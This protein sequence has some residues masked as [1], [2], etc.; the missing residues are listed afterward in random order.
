MPDPRSAASPDPAPTGG[1]AAAAIVLRP[2]R[3]GDLG[4]VVSRHGA[5]YAAEYGWDARFEG[6]VAG[7]VAHFVERFEPGLECGVIAE[8][9]G[10][11]VGSVF[12]V[13]ESG[14]VAKLRLL[15]VEPSARGIGLGRRLVREAM[16][17]AR[18]AGY[19]EM[20]LWTNEV[21][22][23]ARGIYVAEG[24][25]LQR[26]ERHESFGATLVGEYWSRPL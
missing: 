26:S 16:R 19:R 20:V 10:E 18:E 15:L 24:F 8:R 25:V 5:L 7:I 3:P 4:W 12:V 21:L 17:F 6:M 11:P 22:A 13:R 14:T 2:P 23:A 9:D 1:P